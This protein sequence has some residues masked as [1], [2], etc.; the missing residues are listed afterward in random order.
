METVSVTIGLSGPKLPGP[1]EFVGERF[2]KLEELEKKFGAWPGVAEKAKEWF[3]EHGFNVEK[4][5]SRRPR[6]IRVSGTAKAMEAAFK[7]E[8][9]IYR[10]P[11]G[12]T[13]RG[14]QGTIQIPKELKG[15]ITGVFGVD[16]RPMARR[17]SAAAVSPEQRTALSA[18]TPKKIEERYN[19][20][21]GDGEGQSIAIAQFGGGYLDD[22][23][24]AY[25]KKCRRPTPKRH[26]IS[27]GAPA[28]RLKD[29]LAIQDQSER[30]YQL[31]LSFEVTTDAEIIGGLCPKAS[32]STY[33]STP[34]ESGW[35]NLLDKVIS[36]RPVPVVLSISWGYVEGYKDGQWSPGGI[37][38][39]NDRLNLARLLGITICVS[40]GDDG[41]RAQVYK[42]GGAHVYF[43]S[44][45]PYVLAVGGTMLEPSGEEVAW[46]DNPD[47]GEGASGGGVS[48]FFPRPAWQK[49]RIDSLNEGNFDGRVVPDVSALAGKPYYE[50]RFLNLPW[51]GGLTSVSAPVWAAL[52]ARIN[53]KLPADKKRRFLTPLLYKEMANGTPVGKASC[54]DITKGNN[55]ARLD[56]DADPIGYQARK[57]FD[58][59]TGWG[60]PD[61]MR[62]LN[63]LKQI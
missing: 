40:S 17:M 24:A 18:F 33:F 45:S 23:V 37:R 44:S 19:F 51:T 7:P 62:L 55:A 32:I 50:L 43:P 38:A 56:P 46:C 57:G 25:C 9:A 27:A 59:V 34:D 13:H 36:A 58:A 8:W 54:R 42:G 2:E 11:D 10:S 41:C 31:E 16:Q 4:E 26:L 30:K 49:V 12:R 20:P 28:N 47:T 1:D 52:I 22:D 6:S 15:I 60:V 5:V 63:Y 61:G 29:I 21:P 14:R 3:N 39:I 35:V 53:A 48:R